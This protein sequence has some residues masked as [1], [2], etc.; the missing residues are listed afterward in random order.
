MTPARTFLRDWLALT[1]G[2]SIAGILAVGLGM[3][4]AWSIDRARAEWVYGPSDATYELPDNEM[5]PADPSV[6]AEAGR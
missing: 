6:F 2:F 3:P 5:T 4:L 1:L